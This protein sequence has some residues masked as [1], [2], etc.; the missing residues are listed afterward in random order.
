MQS[1]LLI[2]HIHRSSITIF[3]IITRKIEVKL[4]KE[5][6]VYVHLAAVGEGLQL[7]AFLHLRYLF[8]FCTLLL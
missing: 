8:V 5:K 4:Q 6:I 7:L 1:L 2:C 3:F